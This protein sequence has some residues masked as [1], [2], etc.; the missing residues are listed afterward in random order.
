LLATLL[1]T[2]ISACMI[3]ALQDARALHAMRRSQ[4]AR[5]SLA[6]LLGVRHDGLARS[7]ALDEP[8]LVY[9]V[10]GR[11]ERAGHHPFDDPRRFLRGAM[12]RARFVEVG[13][14]SGRFAG[15]RPVPSAVPPAAEVRGSVVLTTESPA[16]DF[17]VLTDDAGMIHGLGDL[18]AAPPQPADARTETA[19][20]AGF[21]APY[22]PS[23]R[24]TAY[25]VLAESRSACRLG[26]VPRP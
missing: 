2:V 16:P 1:L 6:L 7:V 25:A 18:A 5:L 14:C 21:I 8:D 13:R 10:A 9:R 19:A 24:Y 22:R 17:I 4:A 11:L 26:S 12:L 15:T 20:W 3:P 23:D